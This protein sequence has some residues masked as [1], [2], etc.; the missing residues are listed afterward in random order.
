MNNKIFIN[1][2]NK[3]NDYLLYKKTLNEFGNSKLVN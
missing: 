1:Y 3:K 2:L